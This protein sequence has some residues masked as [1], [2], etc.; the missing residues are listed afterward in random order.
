MSATLSEQERRRLADM[1]AVYRMFDEN[2]RLVYVG[3]TAHPGQRFGQHA[4]KRWFTLVTTITLEWHD[5]HAQAVLAERDA[6]EAERP[7]YNIA[8]TPRAAGRPSVATAAA[9]PVLDL[10]TDWDQLSEI[11][12][13]F[14][15]GERGLFWSTVAIRLMN[16]FPKRWPTATRKS[17][18]AL[19]RALGVPSVNVREPRKNP[20]LGCRR[21]D[22]KMARDESRA[23]R[24]LA[25]TA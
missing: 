22:V 14:R 25:D 2:G 10:A 13:I 21:A 4:E 23:S 17:V 5:T 11:L 9:E 19:A 7:R 18:A 24:A 15:P 1:R 3:Q 8:H 20:A 12:A 16:Q 6:I